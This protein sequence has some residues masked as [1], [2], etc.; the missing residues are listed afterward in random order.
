MGTVEIY[1]EQSKK[2]K[3]LCDKKWTKDDADVVCRELGYKASAE[4]LLP[5]YV[6]DGTAPIW[7]HELLCNGS[8]YSTKKC[9]RAASS[10]NCTHEDDVGVRCQLDGNY[11]YDFTLIQGHFE[12]IKQIFISLLNL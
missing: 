5:K 2:W 9:E 6:D 8:E 1:D 11:H 12:T 7:S 3:T 4:P 10:P